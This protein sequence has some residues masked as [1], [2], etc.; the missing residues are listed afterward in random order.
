VHE[1]SDWAA[2]AR[3]LLPKNPAAAFQKAFAG[4]T[5]E[6]RKLFSIICRKEGWRVPDEKKKIV[7]V[8]DQNLA[9]VWDKMYETG[10]RHSSQFDR[11]MSHVDGAMMIKN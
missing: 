5:G 1:L 11:E 9:E 4:I 6:V 8:T 2:P 3:A 7:V 10:P